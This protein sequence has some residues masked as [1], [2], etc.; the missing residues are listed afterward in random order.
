MKRYLKLTLYIPLLVLLSL[1]FQTHASCLNQNPISSKALLDI[2][3]LKLVPIKQIAFFNSDDFAET[4]A[5]YDS[6]YIHWRE[7]R[8]CYEKQTKIG[9]FINNALTTRKGY[10]EGDEKDIIDQI[11]FW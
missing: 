11:L 9:E 8:T 7:A 2:K 3:I 5:A 1:T 6:A 4:G 10:V